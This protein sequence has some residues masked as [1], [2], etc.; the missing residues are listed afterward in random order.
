MRVCHD[1]VTQDKDGFQ[2]IGK[3]PNLFYLPPSASPLTGCQALHTAPSRPARP[4]APRAASPLGTKES[5][6]GH[7]IP[8][9]KNGSLIC[10]PLLSCLVKDV[11]RSASNNSSPMQAARRLAAGACCLP[12]ANYLSRAKLQTQKAAAE[13]RQEAAAGA[14]LPLPAG[15]RWK[16]AADWPSPAQDLAGAQNCYFPR[17]FPIR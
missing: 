15:T 17:G 12:P 3:N 8:L 2:V 6:V 13:P 9:Q 5:P 11:F 16:P 4:A 1:L 14:P 10:W 7:L